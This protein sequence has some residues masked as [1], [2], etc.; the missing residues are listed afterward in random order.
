L[1]EGT[2]RQVQKT[3]ILKYSN[4]QSYG[5]IA[6]LEQ[7]DAEHAFRQYRFFLQM[8]RLVRRNIFCSACG[9]IAAG[10]PTL[11]SSQHGTGTRQFP[12]GAG[13]VKMAKC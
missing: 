10:A 4:R 9:V 13:P 5:D 12:A 7:R 6:S 3:A 1:E 11:E 2:T 8:Q